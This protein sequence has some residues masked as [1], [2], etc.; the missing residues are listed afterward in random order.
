[1]MHKKCAIFCSFIAFVTAK[2]HEL[3]QKIL[4]SGLRQKA[5]E[6]ERIPIMQA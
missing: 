1:M 2:F 6:T 3:G 5:R 4:T